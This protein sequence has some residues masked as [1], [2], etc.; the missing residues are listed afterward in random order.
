MMLKMAIVLRTVEF[1]RGILPQCPFQIMLT[2][3]HARVEGASNEYLLLVLAP[4]S[5]YKVLVCLSPISQK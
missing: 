3:V 1:V 5:R 4:F 2:Y